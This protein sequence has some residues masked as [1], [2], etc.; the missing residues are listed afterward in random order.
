MA[1]WFPLCV[2][3]ETFVGFLLIFFAVPERR[4]SRFIDKF[5]L[6]ETTAAYKLMTIA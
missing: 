6:E 1:N 3:D 2:Q 5:Y 4:G